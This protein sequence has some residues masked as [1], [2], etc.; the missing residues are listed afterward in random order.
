MKKQLKNKKVLTIIG[1]R[2]E[3]VKMAPV[4]KAIESSVLLSSFVCT[5]SQH[6]KM[7][8]DMVKLFELDVDF[9]LDIMKPGQTLVHTT[10]IVLSKIY[11]LLDELKPD[12]VL[13]HGDTTT[14]FAASLAAF[15]KQIPV[16]HVEAG[17]RT[18]DLCNPFPEEANRQLTSKLASFHFAPTEMAKSNLLK[19]K[20]SSE[21]IFVT[22]NTVVDAL[23]WAVD[24]LD[25]VNATKDLP[26]EVVKLINEN[27]PYVL[28]T[29]HRRESFGN[30]F[31]SICK[32]I[33][34]LSNI[35]P[36]WCFIYP[37]HLNP[38]VMN[39]VYDFLSNLPNVYLI[40][41]VDY[42]P[43]VYLMKNSKIILSDSGGVQEEAPSLGKPVL[44]MRDKTERPEG[45]KAGI[46]RLV[47]TSQDKIIQNVLQLIDDNDVYLQM[48]TATNPYGDGF[49]A[50]KICNVIESCL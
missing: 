32:A 11:V 12:I 38:N 7:Q 16:G 5:T 9:D 13:V 18:Y 30:G 41:P 36:D 15:Y 42:F 20:I 50:K 43:F 45:V 26:D 39:P 17:L 31:L 47:G 22:G 40:S 6:R 1:T 23:L 27:H 2:P 3:V 24:H 19:D 14:S 28:I 44:V 34:V 21:K 48:I 33:R 35:R 25:K 49:A 4:I 8:D 29:A 46:A 37:V 10:T